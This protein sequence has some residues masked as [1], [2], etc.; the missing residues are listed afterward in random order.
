MWSYK[1]SKDGKVIEVTDNYE[2]K[3]HPTVSHSSVNSRAWGIYT[4]LDTLSLFDNN[5]Y[6]D[7]YCNVA[8]II[9]Y[10]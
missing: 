4:I 2:L 7:M 10:S 8:T 9:V 1:L 5:F 6:G 3:H